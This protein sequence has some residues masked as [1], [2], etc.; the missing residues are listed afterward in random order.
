M[1]IAGATLVSHAVQLDFPILPVIHSLLGF[2]DEVVVNVGPA[3]DGTLDLIASIRDRRVRVL[4]GNWDGRDGGRMLAV[5]TNRALA[6]LHADWAI[7]LQADEVLHEADTPLLRAAL[8]EADRDPGVEG[9]LFDYLH[10]YGSFRRLATNRTWIRRE[11]RAIRPGSPVASY[12]EAQGFRVTPGGRRVRAR[13][14]GCRI[15]HYGWARPIDA[16]NTKRERDHALYHGGDGRPMR[17]AIPSRLQG[18]IGLVPY[19]G[20]HPAV[21]QAWIAER[22]GKLPPDLDPLRWTPRQ[23]QLALLH[24]LERLTGWRPFEFRNYTIV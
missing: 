19:R 7:Y 22:E 2:C 3:D 10:F 23:V 4:R 18:E 8:A 12:A 24:G 17:A 20:S 15:F 6:G 11:V 9:L 13:P 14:C 16:L 1:R 5:E 21:A